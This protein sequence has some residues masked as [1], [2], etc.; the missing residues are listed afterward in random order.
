VRGQLE[1]QPL[2][3]Q[4]EQH[5]R[6]NHGTP[7]HHLSEIVDVASSVSR[8]RKKEAGEWEEGVINVVSV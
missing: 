5:C 1:H 3:E 2:H 6:D 8:M 4:Q 7:V